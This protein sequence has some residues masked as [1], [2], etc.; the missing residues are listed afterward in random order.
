MNNTREEAKTVC[1]TI[2]HL[3]RFLEKFI[4]SIILNNV[5][6]IIEQ[7]PEFSRPR[8]TGVLL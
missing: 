7:R 6:Y 5:D 3:L 2:S 4:S 1:N 8:L